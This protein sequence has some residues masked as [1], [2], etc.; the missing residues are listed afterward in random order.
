MNANLNIFLAFFAG[1]LSFLSPC[2]LPLIPSYLSFVSGVSFQELSQRKGLDRGVIMLRTAFFVLGF[3]IVFVILGI[4][5][6]GPALLFSG[7]SRWINLVAGTIVVLLGFN[8]IFDFVKGLNLER[9]V[10][11]SN[12]PAGAAGAIVVGMAFGAGWSP[13]IG[14][15]LA[16]ILFLAGSESETG[17][18]AVLLGVYSLGLGLPFLLAGAAFT[19]VSASLQ[20]IK[21]YFPVIKT[22]SGLFLVVVGLLIAFGRFQQLNGFLAA[23]A[24]RLEG[25]SE[26]NPG[27][28]R[29]V[30]GGGAVF[31]GLLHP[32]LRG[33]RKKPLFR[34]VGTTVAVVFIAAGLAEF[35]GI[36]DLAGMIAAW[37]A[38]QGV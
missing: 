30:L 26:T 18:A 13:C 28:A 34:P 35:A 33:I 10:H 4:L 32:I 29:I 5:F 12:R 17:R 36:I 15:I 21:P 3:T 2:V 31:L 1:I 37:L 20:K 9:R 19:R 27:L 14:P 6:A 11:L 24:Y 22:V 25:W 7:A 23:T 16:S 38:Y 8:V